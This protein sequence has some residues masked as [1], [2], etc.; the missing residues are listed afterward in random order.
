MKTVFLTG[1]IVLLTVSLSAQEDCCK[2]GAK[3]SRKQAANDATQQTPLL[4][5]LQPKDVSLYLVPLVCP[6]A[7]EIGCGGKAKPILKQLEEQEG[8]SQAWLNREGTML[9]I[10][11]KPNANRSVSTRAIREACNAQKLTLTPLEG[12][13]FD[14]ALAKFRSGSGWYRAENV[15]RL[16]ERE[17]EVIVE[18]IVRRLKSKIAL[19][20]EKSGKLQAELLSR[21]KDL[22]R[23]STTDQQAVEEEL[24]RSVQSFLSSEELAT[25]KE[26]IALGFR[27]L[28]N[29]K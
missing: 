16:S 14:Q 7:P 19:S 8:V 5:S 29:E 1:L 25:L 10:V 23:R 24:Y 4:T 26:A 9:A 3:S 15:D 28:E 2:P 18:R 22:L 13:E 20:D 21:C 6:A 12:K 17:A 11:W 27:P